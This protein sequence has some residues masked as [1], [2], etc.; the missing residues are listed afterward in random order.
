MI[1]VALG[2][3]N[4][5][6]NFHGKRGIRDPMEGKILPHSYTT[7]FFALLC[8]LLYKEN[9]QKEWKERA[10]KSLMAELDILEE[11]RVKRYPAENFH[12]E[13]KNYALINCY[14][15]IENEL[16]P[17]LKKRL[18]EYILCW[19]DLNIDSTN[20]RCMRALSYY[21]R[22]RRFRRVTDI[23]RSRLELNIVLRRQTKEGFFPD[24]EESYS[25][26]Y[27]A[28]VLALLYQ[29]YR[30]T[31]DESVRKSFL[32]G[33]DFIID[34]IDPVG[35]FNYHGRGQEQ[36]FGYGSLIFCLEGAA[37]IT[38]NGRYKGAAE[39]V[40]SYL[41]GFENAEGVFPLVLNEHQAQKA[42]WYRY[43]NLGDYL[44]F[45][46]VYLLCAARESIDLKPAEEKRYTRFYPELGLFVARRKNYF[47]AVSA[48]G[49]SEI[50]GIAHIYPKV[51]PCPGGP[52]GP[53]APGMEGDSELNYVGP[54]YQGNP[55]KNKQAMMGYRQDTVRLRY[56]LA[57]F[58]I[59]Y[60]LCLDDGVKIQLK[61]LPKEKVKIVPLHVA[62]FKKPMTNLE[63][64]KKYDVLTPDG[65][66]VGYESEVK[67]LE[68]DFAVTLELIKPSKKEC[69]E[70]EAE[71]F[72][73]VRRGDWKN[74]PLRALC[75]LLQKM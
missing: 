73:P 46:G 26:Q 68:D 39:K 27:H 63:I 30:Y 61:I 23:I 65:K 25:F 9:A 16:D 44:S 28:Y 20:W 72:K 3:G 6:K 67:T 22:Y 69:P 19:R 10:E 42:G 56:N 60:L 14:I 54:Y 4:Y 12:W 52:C 5:L 74:L 38:R 40:L 47:I 8:G 51:L 24:T 11:E 45:L 33:V 17:E 18:R 13:F 64:Q 43:N 34:F 31:K 53:H 50:G 7:P 70:I 2:I 49:H 15:L 62:A 29:Y 48:G 1:K 58:D 66:A 37:K 57:D 59:E 35:D 21:L 75:L 32:R 71:M 55:I 36:I 41:K